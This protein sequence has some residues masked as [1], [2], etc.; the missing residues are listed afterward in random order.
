M[1]VLSL[2]QGKRP[3]EDPSGSIGKVPERSQGRSTLEYSLRGK[4]TI[5]L[6]L[7]LWNECFIPS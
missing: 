2:V 1:K 6:L 3:L 7:L 5:T 4:T